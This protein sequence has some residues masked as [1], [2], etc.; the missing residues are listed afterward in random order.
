MFCFLSLIELLEKRQRQVYSLDFR[1][2]G[3]LVLFEEKG[4]R[5]YG[6]LRKETIKF[7]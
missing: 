5:D 2:F 3:Y 7:F 4:Y 1:I 6:M